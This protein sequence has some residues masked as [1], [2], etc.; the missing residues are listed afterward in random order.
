M[1]LAEFMLAQIISDLRTRGA[2]RVEAFPHRGD[3]CGA[4][5]LWTGPEAIFRRAGFRAVR[6]D[7]EKPVLALDL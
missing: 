2:R 6:D 1:G 7:P 3:E 5:D 4:S